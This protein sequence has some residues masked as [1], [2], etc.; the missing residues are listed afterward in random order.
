[1]NSF[2]KSIIGI[3]KTDQALNKVNNIIAGVGFVLFIGIVG[4]IAYKIN[5]AKKEQDKRLQNNQA[6]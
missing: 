2:E 3:A 6:V 4:V 1:M 5:K